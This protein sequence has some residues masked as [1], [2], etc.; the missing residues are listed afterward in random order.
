MVTDGN[1]AMTDEQHNASLAA[2]YL[3]FGD[4]LS[5]EETIAALRA[6]SAATAAQ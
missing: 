6:G 3:K 2:F 1:A 5:T 4:I